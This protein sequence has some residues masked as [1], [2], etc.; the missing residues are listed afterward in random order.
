[1]TPLTRDEVE[2][3]PPLGPMALDKQRV[4]TLFD[5]LDM[6]RFVFRVTRALEDDA[7]DL[8]WRF[9]NGAPKLYILCSDLFYWACADAED[10]TAQNVEVLEQA[11]KDA[12]AVDH[13]HY[14][15]LLFCCR[16]RK[17]RPQKPVLGRLDDKLRPLFEAC[18]PGRSE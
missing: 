3:W 13:R 14:G 18:G 12:A 4:L 10:V 1:M 2:K 16:V 7:S 9:E 6:A 11:M 5:E 15:A 17:M 8:I